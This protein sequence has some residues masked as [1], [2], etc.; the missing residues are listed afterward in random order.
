MRIVMLTESFAPRI[1]GVE[2]HLLRV[3]QELASRGH[4]VTVL[5]PRGCP[6]LLPEERVGGIRVLRFPQRGHPRAGN[7]EVWLWML[8]R[9]ALLSES[10]AVHVHG[11][12]ALLSWYLPF[13][14]LFPGKPV[15][16]T[17]HGHPG[18]FPLGRRHR[19]ER[20]LAEK[21]C[22]GNLCVGHYLEKWYGTRAS[23]VT[24]GAAD[25][26]REE[27]PKEDGKIVFVG[28]LEED[29]GILLYLRALRVLRETTGEPWK[30]L[31][32]GTGSLRGRVEH[33]AR[34]NGLDVDLAGA[35]PDPL[36]HMQSGRFVFT[37]GYLS[38][39]DAMI[40]RRFVFSAY[41]NPLKR[42]YLEMMPRARDLM[43]ISGSP[44]ELASAF[45]RVLREPDRETA[46]VERAYRFA[47]GQTWDGMA[48]TYLELYGLFGIG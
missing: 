16:I 42:D 22:R 2:K 6:E 45:C 14:F 10:D 32:C 17:F 31:V 36:P 33:F 9:L 40:C 38:L 27:H 21:L 3:S 48:R 4:S 30:L 20:R 39:L 46:C 5:T 8:R 34:E 19:F 29:T 15:F 43:E 7:T 25:A 26:P 23:A 18:G 12:T 37:S 35:V 41:E 47:A 13:R 1:G 44:E 11:Q 28:R 24:Y